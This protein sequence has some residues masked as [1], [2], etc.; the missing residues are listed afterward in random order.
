MATAAD[1]LF[2]NEP[3]TKLGYKRPRKGS[4][5]YIKELPDGRE[6][7]VSFAVASSP[8]PGKTIDVG[9]SFGVRFKKVGQLLKKADPNKYTI[10]AGAAEFEDIGLLVHGEVMPYIPLAS[11]PDSWE[12][13]HILADIESAESLVLPRLESLESH[14][15][16]IRSRPG[17]HK[18]Y[19][20]PAVLALLGRGD[21]AMSTARDFLRQIKDGKRGI[22][23]QN[24]PAYQEFMSNL[25]RWLGR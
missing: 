21:E 18:L 23:E 24:A 10:F 12:I 14:L 13:S 15:E 6:A 5:L 2:L 11:H 20:E 8:D 19:S 25:E 17:D 7:A 1:S 4:S 3:M 9:V 16:A 22:S